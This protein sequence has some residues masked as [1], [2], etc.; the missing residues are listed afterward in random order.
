MPLTGNNFWFEF[1]WFKSDIF[2]QDKHEFLEWRFRRKWENILHILKLE[3]QT[4]TFINLTTTIMYRGLIS[5]F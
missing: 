2:P 4:S 5:K 1:L 3:A